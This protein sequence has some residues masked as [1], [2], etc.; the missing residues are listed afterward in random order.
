ME[1]GKAVIFDMDGVFVDSEGIWKSAEHEVFSSLGVQV[2]DEHSEMTR[3]MTTSEVTNFWYDKFPWQGKDLKEVEQMVI[4]MVID[5]IEREE[6]GIRGVKAFIEKLKERNFK[7]GLA[8]NSPYEV[9]PVVLRKLG[10]SELFDAVTSAEFERK[11]KPDPSIY[12]T[13]AR[14]LNIC[15]ERCFVIEDSHSGMLAAKNAGMAVIAF[16]SDKSEA[17]LEMADYRIDN[18]ERESFGFLW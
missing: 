14:K 4:A 6:C 2:T 11:G 1:E 3:S 16:S 5:L 8:T 15:P 12:Y 17:D 13:V 9:I 10:V 18:F 7:V